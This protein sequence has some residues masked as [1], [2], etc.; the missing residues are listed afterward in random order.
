MTSTVTISFCGGDDVWVIVNPT[1]SNRSLQ[2]G[3]VRLVVTESVTTVPEITYHIRLPG[4]AGTTKFLETEPPANIF[5]EV[6]KAG[7]LARY[8]DLLPV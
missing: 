6:D 5:A 8:G 4:D 2:K 7:A 3:L 1:K